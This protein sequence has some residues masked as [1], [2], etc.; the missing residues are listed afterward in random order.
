MIEF[1]CSQGKKVALEE[2][3]VIKKCF[4]SQDVMQRELT[5]LKMFN[6]LLPEF[7]PALIEVGT[8]YFL[9]EYATSYGVS[10]EGTNI[11]AASKTYVE[12]C[13]AKELALVYQRAY[14][15]APELYKMWTASLYKIEKDFRL[16]CYFLSEI[17]GNRIYAKVCKDLQ[18]LRNEVC[19]PQNITFLHRDLHTGNVV[20]NDYGIKLIDFEHAM[21]GPFELE[22]QNAIFWKD[23]KSLDYRKI[24][25]SVVQKTGLSYNFELEK[26]LGSFYTADQLTQASKLNDLKKISLLLSKL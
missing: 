8:T 10:V 13:L 17:G 7:T 9:E 16:S 14:N 21:A 25:C 6:M 15:R 3:V 12:D 26:L 22:F 24:I 4:E 2:G 11:V 20:I 19:K 23:S 18:Q 5:G 1:A